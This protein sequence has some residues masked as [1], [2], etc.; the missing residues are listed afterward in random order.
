MLGMCHH[1]S[2]R[3]ILKMNSKSLADLFLMVLLSEAERFA[4]NF[5][6]SFASS[7]SISKSLFLIWSCDVIGR[8]LVAIMLLWNLR[9][10]AVYTMH[11]RWTMCFKLFCVFVPSVSCVCSP[12]HNSYVFFASTGQV[13]F[14]IVG[15][16]VCVLIMS[17]LP[18]ILNL[19]LP[20]FRLHQL[21]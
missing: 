8:R 16:C 19:E 7:T 4:V 6:F 20:H 10:L 15:L 3:L 12:L 21:K 5:V 11:W 18:C 9:S 2:A 13:H 1:L 14:I 17:Q